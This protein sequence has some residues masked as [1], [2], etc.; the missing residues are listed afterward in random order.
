MPETTN[1]HDDDR[2]NQNR[3][4]S[5]APNRDGTPASDAT[6]VTPE[7]AAEKR[8]FNGDAA[9]PAGNPPTDPLGTEGEP[10][11]PGGSTHN[12]SDPESKMTTDPEPRDADAPL[13][14]HSAGIDAPDAD[15]P[16]DE[17]LHRTPS[18]DVTGRPERA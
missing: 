14:H 10:E 5:A 13:P 8:G 1:G 3:H 9:A 6:D 12:E 4:T 16:S 18:R 17:P 15:A 7:D 2:E 11:Q